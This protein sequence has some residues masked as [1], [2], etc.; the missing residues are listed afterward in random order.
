MPPGP[1]ARPHGPIPAD[2]DGPPSP[3]KPKSP[4]P[5]N[6]VTTPPGETRRTRALAPSLTQSSPAG[7]TARPRGPARRA[8][9]AGP[10]SPEKPASPVPATVAIFP[11]VTSILRTRCPPLSATNTSPAAPTARATGS[12]SE[13][14][15]AGPPSPAEPG[16]PFP[17]SVVMTSVARSILRTRWFI[18]SAT[19]RR[20]AAS[21]ARARGRASSA[22]DAGP[23]SPPKPA[24]PVPA[25]VSMTP[26]PA[27]TRRIR[28]FSESAT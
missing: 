1:T 9:V 14:A 19:R 25:I 13:A 3:E 15:V 20:P 28:S 24:W 16:M 23:P 10:S 27:F 21:T 12:F 8:A 18:E 5:A 17:A 7:P 26:V 6:V 2:A 22:P 11:L 4:V